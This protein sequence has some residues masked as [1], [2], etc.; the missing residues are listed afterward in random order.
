MSNRGGRLSAKRCIITGAASGIGRTACAVFAREGAQII[1]ADI[2]IEGAK[3]TA[4][5]CGANA[6]AC[7]L[8]VSSPESWKG[9]IDRALSEFGRLDILINCAG[10]GRNGDFEDFSV[11]DWNDLISVNLTGTFLGCQAAMRVM[12]RAR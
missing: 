11:T 1:C 9:C 7:D 8:D 10:I 4:G 5:T 2:N 3:I 12:R 6:V